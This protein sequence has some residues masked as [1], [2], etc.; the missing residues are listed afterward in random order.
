VRLRSDL[1]LL[2]TKSALDWTPFRDVFEVDGS[3]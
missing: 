2:R 1:L 3:P